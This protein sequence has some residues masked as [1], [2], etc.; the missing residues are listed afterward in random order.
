MHSALLVADYLL[1]HGK[2]NLT[3]LHVIKLTYVSHGYT[4]A[5][6]DRPLVLDI[7]EAWPY[8]PVYPILYDYLKAFGAGTVTRLP[9]CGTSISDEDIRKRRD[10]LKLRI[11]K[12]EILD[13]VLAKFGALTGSELIDITHKAGSPWDTCY[14]KGKRA[15][16]PDQITKRYYRSILA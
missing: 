10:S 15:I 7:V 1:A 14:K 3:P 9:Y 6:R 8:G 11:G 13:T 5:I 4:L 2:G 16:I 12:T